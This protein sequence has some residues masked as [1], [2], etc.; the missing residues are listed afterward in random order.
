MRWYLM[1][2]DVAGHAMTPAFRL[3]DTPVNRMAYECL[4]RMVRD[5]K[6][7]EDVL[8]VNAINGKGGDDCV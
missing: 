1:R 7:P 4:S 8:K 3:F 2:E 6:H 5:P